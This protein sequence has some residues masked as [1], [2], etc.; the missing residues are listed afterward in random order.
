MSNI[1]TERPTFC[2]IGT[3]S[4]V[5]SK[6]KRDCAVP[7]TGGG[8]LRIG[9]RA[10][11]RTPFGMALSRGSRVVF[12]LF[13]LFTRNLSK[14]DGRSTRFTRNDSKW[15]SEGNSRPSSKAL[16]FLQ[17]KKPGSSR[18]HDVKSKW[19]S[20][21]DS[22]KARKLDSMDGRDSVHVLSGI[23]RE[24]RHHGQLLQDIDRGQVKELD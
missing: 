18:V 11:L 5:H 8:A 15:Y 1:S 24:T 23:P 14:G 17:N 10:V 2:I 13:F 6:Y 21:A 12:F 7:P 16:S 19:Y 22:G 20:E 3:V 4:R 9:L